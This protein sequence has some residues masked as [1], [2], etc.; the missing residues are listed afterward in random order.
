MVFEAFPR[1]VCV[2]DEGCKVKIPFSRVGSCGIPTVAE[3]SGG[4][5][6]QTR[7]GKYT[8]SDNSVK[9][10]ATKMGKDLKGKT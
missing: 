4:C 9:R 2:T 5:I 6:L 3:K 1:D 8:D 10:R 7:L